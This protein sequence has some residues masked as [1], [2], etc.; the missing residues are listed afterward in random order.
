MNV[1]RLSFVALA[2]LVALVGCNT[3]TRTSKPTYGPGSGGSGGTGGTASVDVAGVQNQQT[4]LLGTTI[5]ALILSLQN[6]STS[7]AATVTSLTVT[8]A[9]T[10]DEPTVITTAAVVNDADFSGTADQGETQVAT[11]AQP[12][13]SANDGTVVFSINP[14]L[15]IPANSTVQLIVTVTTVAITG[16]S[17]QVPIVGQSVRLLINAATD[18]GI[19]GVTPTG[20]FP[21]NGN[22]CTLGIGAHLLITEVFYAAGGGAEFI[23]IFNPTPSTVQ[24]VNYHLTDY[25]Q[26]VAL[27]TPQTQPTRF[28]YLLP[29]AFNNPPNDAF[30]P[31]NPTSAGEA[32]FSIRFPSNATIDPGKFQVIAVDGGAG[33]FVTQFPNVTPTYALR[34]ATAPTVAML[35]WNPTTQ[36]F[37]AGNVGTGVGLTDGGEQVMLFTWDGGANPVSDLVTD[38]DIVGW[39]VQSS[40]SLNNYM[41][42]KTGVAVDGPDANA[43]TTTYATETPPNTQETNRL[44]AASTG[45]SMQR[46]SYSE[47][48]E[49][50]QNGNGIGGHDE[51]SEVWSTNFVNGAPTPGAP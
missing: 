47:S 49:A 35:V 4:A 43:T 27:S 22:A 2:T 24:L 50:A 18:I 17:N 1:S 8:A 21:I 7:A 6:T 9:G 31:V 41:V 38:V 14:P 42:S 29:T 11:A 44:S 46:T 36:V 25:T 3:G 20:T 12:A 19:T 33:G 45:N 32:D 16:N 37:S 48:G 10:V 51:T 30:G 23:E 13:F 40:G 34:N 39:G 26:T 15:S 28:Y 5:N